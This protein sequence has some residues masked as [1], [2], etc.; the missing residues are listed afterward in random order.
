MEHDQVTI[1][2]GSFPRGWSPARETHRK[3]KELVSRCT[4]SVVAS[5]MG[6]SET[7]PFLYIVRMERH[8]IVKD[9][10]QR[11]VVL[12][13]FFPFCSPQEVNFWDTKEV[14]M[15]NSVA[16]HGCENSFVCDFMLLL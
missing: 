4:A 9:L 8:S 2:A 15:V 13:L 1:V 12:T 10:V 3:N 7:L 11:R 5:V 6:Q 16:R 14:Q